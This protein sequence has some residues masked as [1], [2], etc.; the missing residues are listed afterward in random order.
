MTLWNSTH[1][2]LTCPQKGCSRLSVD[3]T[4]VSPGSERRAAHRGA[5]EEPCVHSANH[6]RPRTEARRVSSCSG[7]PVGAPRGKS[8]TTPFPDPRVP[9]LSVG[10]RRAHQSAPLTQRLACPATSEKP[11]S[12][13]KWF[14]YTV[15]VGRRKCWAAMVRAILGFSGEAE[16]SSLAQSAK[17]GPIAQNHRFLAL[18]VNLC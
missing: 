17:F 11:A 3:P 6:Q 5:L 13:R 16:P 2:R 14:K 4:D 8:T 1:Q 15:H 18:R 10:L 7:H 9:K 12:I